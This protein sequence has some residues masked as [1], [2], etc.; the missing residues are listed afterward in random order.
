MTKKGPAEIAGSVNEWLE[1]FM[2]LITPLGILA[3]FLFPRIFIK[4]RPLVPLLFGI[5]TLSGALKLKLREFGQ[6]IKSPLGIG[7]FLL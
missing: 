5:M 6:T 7:I 3:G 2:P 1:R 4:L